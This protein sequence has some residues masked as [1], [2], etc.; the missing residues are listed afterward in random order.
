MH[1]VYRQHCGLEWASIN[2]L[3]SPNSLAYS[4]VNLTVI[5]GMQQLKRIAYLRSILPVVYG[6]L[7][8]DC[9]ILFVG[10]LY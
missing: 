8:F 2:T 9:Q 5:S 7:I 1:C 6:S 10:H 3:E 4:L